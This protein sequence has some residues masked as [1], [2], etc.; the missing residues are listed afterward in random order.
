LGLSIDTFVILVRTSGISLFGVR[1]VGLGLITIYFFLWIGA[2]SLI[3]S[4]IWRRK[5]LFPVKPVLVDYVL[6]L[7]IAIQSIMIFI[8]FLA[9][10]IFPALESGDFQNHVLETRDT[11][12]G[13]ILHQGG[14]AGGLGLLYQ[15][16]HY[17]SASGG[18]PICQQIGCCDFG[19]NDG[20]TSNL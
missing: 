19:S 17:L 18:L 12:T 20:N 11:I 5:F 6:F 3:P 9:N 2:I 16:V 8:Y 13:A 7:I 4:I 1:L 14:N 15:G 10:P